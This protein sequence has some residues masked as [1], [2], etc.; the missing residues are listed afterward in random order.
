MHAVSYRYLD[1]LPTL[2]LSIKTLLKLV[3][4]SYKQWRRRTPTRRSFATIFD[5]SLGS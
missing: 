3:T 1:C 4:Y 5:L 2:H